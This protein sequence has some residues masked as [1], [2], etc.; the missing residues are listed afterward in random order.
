MSGLCFL[1]WQAQLLPK[2]HGPCLNSYWSGPGV[3][4]WLV[5]TS[6]FRT[7]NP[8]AVFLFFWQAQL[9]SKA[10]EGLELFGSDTEQRKLAGNVSWIARACLT[11]VHVTIFRHD[12]LVILAG[13]AQCSGGIH[14]RHPHSVAQIGGP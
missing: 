13:N 12:P 2:A 5:A 3:T 8:Q 10:H 1:A 7:F 14:P 4:P 11:A 9:L 6:S